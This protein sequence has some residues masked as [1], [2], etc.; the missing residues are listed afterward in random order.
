MSLKDTFERF[1]RKM[2]ARRL[3]KVHDFERQKFVEEVSG[4]IA[5][6]AQIRQ[7]D[8]QAR[9]RLLYRIQRALLPEFVIADHG[10]VILEDESF[11]EFFAHFSDENWTSFERKW[12]LKELLKLIADVPGDF[13]ECGVFRGGSAY[14]LCEQAQ[15]SNR[16]VHLFDSFA[17]LSQPMDHENDHWTAGDL[18]IT[19]SEVRQNLKQ[20]DNFS[21]Y[22]GWIPERFSEVGD[23]SFAFVHIDV[24]LD[25]PT[26][27]SI[28]HFFPRLSPGGILLLDD[29][30]SAMCPG[31]RTAALDYF[32]PRKE[33]VLDLATGQGLVV[34]S[35]N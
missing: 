30:G 2:I 26:A 13:A 4:F 32:A 18:A 14:L 20:F 12:N 35:H 5:E 8:A 27:D 17:G 6:Q 10:R 11:R 7:L 9:H 3:G 34:K 1:L 22:P 28:A 16:T 24:D 33:Q 15:V 23:R 19:E 21:T 31:A 29:H 25:Q